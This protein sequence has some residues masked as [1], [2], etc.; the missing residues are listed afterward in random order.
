IIRSAKGG[1]GM[2]AV[3]SGAAVV[4]VFVRGSGRAWPRGRRLPRPAKVTVTFGKPLKFEPWRGADRKRQYEIA[5]REM[6]EAIA[7]LRDG[8]TTGGGSQ[9]WSES[10][11]GRSK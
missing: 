6:M 8:T 1:A 4:P 2:L 11:A 5:S 9:R 3:L 7:R 10:Y